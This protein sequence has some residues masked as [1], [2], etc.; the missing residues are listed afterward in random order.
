MTPRQHSFRQRTRLGTA[1]LSLCLAST[2]L[3]Q[4]QTQ[5]GQSN[6]VMVVFDASGSMW[7]QV[8]GTAKVEIA[9]DVFADL[10]EEWQRNR[11]AVGLIAYGHRRR[12]D[13][14]DI[15]VLAQPSV[16]GSASLAQ[17]VSS[18]SPRGKTPLSQAVRTAAEQ[19]LYTENAATVVLLSDGIETCDLDPCAVGAE[20]ESL[21]FDFTAHVIGFDIREEADRAQLQCLADTTGGTYMDARD[22]AT[23]STALAQAT[24]G[25]DPRLAPE[26]K[27]TTTATKITVEIADGTARPAF[28][29][30]SAINAETGER[31]DLGR[32]EGADQVI[33]GLTFDLPQGDW[34]FMAEGD[35]GTGETTARLTEATQEIPIPFAANTGAFE[36]ISANSFTVD[37]TIAFQLRSLEPLQQNATYSVMLFP[38]G[39]TTFDE[40]ITFS[41]RFGTDPETTD[42]AFYPWEFDLPTGDYEIVIMGDSYDLGDHLGRFPVQLVETL[43]V[44]ETQASVPAADDTT[45]P[46]SFGFSQIAEPLSPGSQNAF[47]IDGPVAP[48][49][50]AMLIGLEG[51]DIQVVEVP[52]DGVV[53][54]PA[55]IVAGT[56]RVQLVRPD[57]TDFHLGLIDAL[58]E[59]AQ[60]IGDHSEGGEPA[61]TMLSAQELAAE[62]GPQELG[63]DPW[64]TCE[65]AVACRV[66]DRRVG[67]EWMLPAGWAAEEPF[68]YTTA[69]GAQADHPT[70]Q[71]ARASGGA[72]SITL[73][74]RQWDVMLGPCEDVASGLLCR[75][76]SDVLKDQTDYEMIRN[77]LN[78]DF[79]KPDGW[80]PI[81]RSWTIEDRALGA[82]VGLIK[83]DEPDDRAETVSASIRL[84]NPEQFGLGDTSIVQTE[85]GLIWDQNLLVNA[86][87][88]EIRFEDGALFVLLA[89]PGGWD[90]TQDVWVGTISNPANHR[91]VLVN[92]Y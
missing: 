19:M 9:Q 67:L 91:A 43:E 1:A 50:Q 92:L 6:D 12:G 72:F 56:Y 65:E 78:G 48:G 80:L 82:R 64:K 18:L 70:M 75:E 27:I 24:G 16:E 14:S 13:C 52:D 62:T 20:L 68:Y 40:N 77:S 85:L 22:A 90:G 35:G 81:G 28:V 32:L 71:M 17:I 3:V 61:D 2:S 83:L 51:Q 57:G 74:P 41:Y 15:E 89:R 88:G 23:L 59:T 49:D 11:Q 69:G 45:P 33:T 87:D 73:N 63:F 76:A 60:D 54:L 30:L 79:P 25:A 34:V 10:S 46:P 38:R 86:I 47:L 37:E 8:D 36:V 4:A 26:V 39:A 7:G 42:H 29:T 66:E 58:P 44:A 21:G 31:R 53:S 84:D 5:S 55:Q